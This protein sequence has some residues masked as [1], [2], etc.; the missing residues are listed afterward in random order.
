[1]NDEKKEH[2]TENGSPDEYLR[3]VSAVKDD[4]YRF[5]S[6]GICPSCLTGLKEQNRNMFRCPSCRRLYYV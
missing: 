2:P 3:K 1:M 4:D 5:L 6:K